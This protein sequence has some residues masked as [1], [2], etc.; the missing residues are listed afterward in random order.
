MAEHITEEQ[1]VEAIKTW[2]KENGVA[3]IAGLV[4]GFAAL[5]GW[6]YYNDYK[7]AQAAA[8]S[9]LYESVQ[10]KISLGQVDDARLQAEKIISEYPRTPYATM[11]ALAAAKQAFAGN[12]TDA[13]RKHLQWVLD[14]SRQQ[15]FLHNAR[16]QLLA[17]MLNA[18]EYDAALSLLAT[19]KAGGYAA[20]YEEMRGDLLLAKGDRSAAH[21]AYNSAL[22]AEGLGTQQ[23][24]V[25]QAKFDDT[26]PVITTT[27]TGVEK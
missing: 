17:L 10:Q 2:W 16:L 27:A 3:V 26:T 20:A 1:Q 18:G 11:A 13:A 6:R 4:I 8:A 24:Q 19:V 5:F 7:D 22:Q 23:R 25:V 21:D 14:N 15:Q 12:N 9:S